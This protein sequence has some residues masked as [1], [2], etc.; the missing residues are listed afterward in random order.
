MLLSSIEKVPVLIAG[1][2][3][4][5]LA[6]SILLS[7]FGVE[8]LLVEADPDTCDHPQA[9]VINARTAEIFRSIG[10]EDAV[11][12]QSDPL[13]QGTVRFVTSVAGE[14][15]AALEPR[16]DESRRAARLAA[17][18]SMGT[19]CPQDLIEPLLA[20]KAQEG[21]GRILFS[22]ELTGL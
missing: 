4:T 6:L 10:I 1:G 14:H 2:G 12:A 18:P 22:T 5:G 20:A 13:A 17:S 9:H 15:L 19:S 7:R 8:S 3:L 11:H 16:F 21:P